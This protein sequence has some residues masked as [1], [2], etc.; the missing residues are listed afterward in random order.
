M[1]AVGS[2]SF[3]IG[4]LQP[5]STGQVFATGNFPSS[6]PNGA[7]G[8]ISVTM[9]VAN[10]SNG[11]ASKN[12]TANNP[13]PPT[14]TTTNPGTT[15]TTT[16]GPGSTTTTTTGGGGGGGSTTTTTS[17]PPAANYGVDVGR[18][19]FEVALGDQIDW[20]VRSWSAGNLDLTGHG[21]TV[22][23]PAETVVQSFYTGGWSPSSVTAQFEYR[24][25]GSWTNIGTFNGTHRAWYNLPS[26]TNAVRATFNGG[27]ALPQ[28]FNVNDSHRIRATAQRPDRDG[29]WYTTPRSVQACG[30]FTSTNAGSRS[31]C[32]SSTVI[33]PAARP[34]PQLWVETGDLRPTSDLTLRVRAGNDWAAQLPLI[35][36]FLALHLPDELEYDSWEYI[37]AGP[38]PAATIIDDYGSPGRT[39]LR[40]DFNETFNVGMSRDIRV[41]VKVAMGVPVG[42]HPITLLEHTNDPT[43]LVE[44]PVSNIADGADV[45]QDG[46]T[47]ELLCGITRSYYVNE[48]AI[49]EAVMLVRGE[50]GLDPL[51]WT[52]LEPPT[53]PCPDIDG[54]TF[55]P[56]VAQT[57]SL[58]A[59]DYRL[60]VYN[61][62][63][64]ELT[65]FTLYNTLPFIGDSGVSPVLTGFP[66]GSEWRPSLQSPLSVVEAPP[67]VVIE[68]SVETNPCRNEIGPGGNWPTG[69][70]DDWGPPPGDLRLVQAIRIRGD[71][72]AGQ[73][74]QGGDAIILEYDMDASQGSPFG[75]EIG[76]TS[77]AYQTE[78]ADDG[79]ELPASEPRKTGMAIK[80]PDNGIGTTI[81]LDEN[82]NGVREAGEPGLNEIRVELYR[83][84]GTLE[85][86]TYSDNLRGDPSQ[87][88]FYFFGDREPGRYYVQ[89][90]LP[91][92]GW[93]IMLPDQGG[94]DTIDSDASILTART[95][96][97]DLGAND[98]QLSWDLA[99]FVPLGP[100]ECDAD[101]S[102][103]DPLDDLSDRREV[104]DRLPCPN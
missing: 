4:T 76:W 67:G 45:D 8:S 104:N 97:I 52:T 49:T 2:T 24:V 3:S 90:E 32:A 98:F 37:G 100:L 10:G 54:Y 18:S 96:I 35:D 92:T 81:W 103:I 41:Y 77:F 84:D 42:N 28:S 88:G 12:V 16:G 6:T 55:Y 62:G 72:P 20:S 68:Y 79:L 31:D 63:N 22:T 59:T 17:P 58:G 43:H 9:N 94:D 47:S 91:R 7:T 27:G 99:Y 36:P 23:L 70:I 46:S 61:A 15:T 85:A 29:G 80:A 66:R 93:N 69:C 26:G 101:G 21:W 34:A 14:T 56:C 40:W 44:C 30:S 39:L 83:E 19:T 48:A 95:P 78:R 50:P 82:R 102:E 75:G 11:N 64:V 33:V 60:E 38:T 87:P 89:F 86:V 1:N 73:R 25:G 71:F 53:T 13:N 57:K 51:D 5:G 65:D 74:W